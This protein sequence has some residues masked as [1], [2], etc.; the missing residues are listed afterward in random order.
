MTKTT[1]KPTTAKNKE[2]RVRKSARH[3]SFRLSKNIKPTFGLLPSSWFLFKKTLR[4]LLMHWRTYSGIAVVYGLLNLLFVRGFGGGSDIALLSDLLRESGSTNRFID[5]IGLLE[6]LVLGS[7][8]STDATAIYQLLILV[9]CSLAAIWAL[10][11]TRKQEKVSA[12]AAFYNGMGPLVPFLLV[13]GIL[14]LMCLPLAA[15]NAIYGIVFVNGIAVLLIEKVLWTLLLVLVVLL[16]IYMLSSAAFAP[17]IVTM[18]DMSPMLAV[19]SSR[20]IARFRRF[21][22]LRKLLFLP[23]ILSLIAGVILVPIIMFLPVIAE[24]VYY[25]LGAVALVVLHGYIYNLYRELL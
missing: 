13:L 23:F 1:K 25:T 2:A 4:H 16:S 7:G 9:I 10:R 12:R 20:N 14:V 8:E 22:I 6:A 19:R 18:P 5:S 17:Y 3:K 24:V 15:A 21:T 11:R